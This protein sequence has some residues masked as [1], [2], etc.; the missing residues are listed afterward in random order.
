M[1]LAVDHPD[2]TM[3]D[4]TLQAIRWRK[5]GCGFK[6]IQ[7]VFNK[8]ISSPWFVA[9]TRVNHDSSDDDDV[10]EEEDDLTDFLTTTF[11]NG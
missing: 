10:D 9:I 5:E 7:L 3:S 4:L 1:Q 6:M 11:K 8:G 2:M